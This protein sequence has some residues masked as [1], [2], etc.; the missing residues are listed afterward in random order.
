MKLYIIEWEDL[1]GTWIREEIVAEDFGA[2][3]DE[4]ERIAHFFGSGIFRCEIFGRDV[5]AFGGVRSE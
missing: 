5:Q 1:D 3:C 2:A 4:A